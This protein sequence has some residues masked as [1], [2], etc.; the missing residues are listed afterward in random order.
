MSIA[1]KQDYARL[2]GFE[3]ILEVV[4]VN[5]PAPPLPPSRARAQI[6]IRLELRGCIG[7]VVGHEHRAD[8]TFAG[9]RGL[10]DAAAVQVRGQSSPGWA[11]CGQDQTCASVW[12][13]APDDIIQSGCLRGTVRGQERRRQVFSSGGA[14][15]RRGGPSTSW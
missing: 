10:Q 8:E 13:R 6:R 5:L 12:H 1:N 14:P 4:R 3:F 15:C 2:H 7:P 9:H 11:A